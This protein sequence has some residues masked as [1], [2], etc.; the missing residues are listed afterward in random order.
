MKTLQYALL[1]L[2]AALLSSTLGFSQTLTSSEFF[3]PE[4]KYKCEDNLIEVMFIETS[5]VRLRNGQPADLI[6]DA[7]TGIDNLLA[8]LEWHQWSR[9]CDVDESVIDRW[10]EDGERNS[11]QP[12]YNLNNIYRLKILEGHDIWQICRQLE[13]LPGI[14]QARPYPLPVEPP[15]PPNYQNNQG[16]LKPSTLN[17][18]GIDALYA[19]TQTGGAGTGITICDL[20]YSWNYNHADITKAVGSSL[21]AWSDPGFGNDH[22]TA[23]IGQLVSN[24]NGWG[25]TGICYDA[26]LK[27]C[28]TYYGTPS[29]V[30]N[31][32]GAMALAIANLSAGDI[33]LLEQQWDYTGTNGYVPIE[34]WTNSN[35]AQTNNAV[36]SAIVNAVA[37]GIHVVE[38]GGNGNINTGS[39][40]WFGYSGAIIVGA[41]GAFTYN[42]RER[43]SF[44]SYGPRFDLQ[45]WGQNVTTTG[46]GDLYNA[47]GIN[48]YYTS[49]FG[50]TSSA[51]PIVTGAIACTQGYYLANVSATPLT[52]SQ[53]RSHLDTYS[54][55]Q[56]FGILGHI[57]PR[58]DLNQAILALQ[59]PP[60]NQYDWGDAPDPSY[61]TLSVNNGARHYIDWTIYLGNGVDADPDGQPNPYALGDDNDGNDDEDGVLFTSVIMANQPATITVFA[62]AN[63]FLNAWFDFNFNGSWND[64]GEQVFTDVPVV[65]GANNLNYFVPPVPSSQYTFTRFRY[66]TLPGLAP[67]G[68]APDGE[69]EDYEIFINQEISEE[70]DWGDAPDSPYPTLGANN[71]A[72]HLIVPGFYLGNFV[73]PEPDGQPSLNAD[74]D[75][76]DCLYPSMGD[77]ED[78][79]TFNYPIIPGQLST[80][81]VIASGTGF[82]N[83][84]IDQDFNNSWADPGDH[85]FADVPLVPGANALNFVA[86]PGGYTGNTYARFRF[87]SLP[88]LTYTGQAPDGEVEDYMIFIDDDGNEFDFGDAPED[89]SGNYPVTLGFNGAHH[90][91]VPGIYLGSFVDPEPDGQ[92]SPGAD[93]DDTDCLF[94]SFGDDEDGVTMPAIINPGAAIDITVTASVDGF[95]DVWIDFNAD[96]DWADPDDHVFINNSLTA[97]ATVLT[98]IVPANASVG[99]SYARFRFRDY[100]TNISYDGYVQNGEVEDYSIIIE[101]PET[102]FDFGDAPEN[103]TGDYPTTLA[104]N[105]ARHIY[106]PTIFLGS[107]VDPEPDGQPGFNADCDDTDCLY[108]SSGDDED[109]VNLPA[110]LAPGSTQIIDVTASVS[111][112]L[113]IWLDIDGNNSW[114]DAG[115]HILANSAMSPGLNTILFFVPINAV[116][117]LQSYMRLRFRDYSGNISYEGL[118]QNGEVEDYAVMFGEPEPGFDF[119]DAPENATGD[120]PTTLAFN[121]AHH[122][123]VPGIFLGNFVDPEPD[124]QP[125][126]GANCDDYDCNYPSLGDDEDGVIIPSVM[127]KG[128]TYTIAVTASVDGYLD[129]WMDFNLNTSWADAGEH[130]F[131]NTFLTAGANALVFNVPANATSGQS[132][133][134][135]RFRDNNA[136]ISFDGYVQNGEVEDYSIIIEDGDVLFDFGDAPENAAGDYPTTLTFNGA[137]HIF[138]PTI[139]LGSFVDPEPDGQ[140]GINADCDDLDCLFPS[141]G[142]DED[143]VVIPSSVS[144][145]TSITIIVTASVDGYLDA[146]M[147][148]NLNTSWSDAGEHIFI[149]A[150]LISGANLLVF[151]VPA[152]ATTGQSYVRFRFRGNNAPISYDG[153]VANGEVEDYAISIDA[154]QINIDVGVILGG[155]VL[156]TWIPGNP[157]IMGTN[158]NSNMYLPLSQPYNDPVA[159]WDYP[160]I[161]NVISIPNGNVVDWLVVELRE[162]AGGPATATAATTIHKQAAFLLNDGSVV[163]LDGFSLP[164]ANYNVTQN[165][166]VVIW[167]RNH[168]G[169]MSANPMSFDG[170][171][172]YSYDFISSSGAAYGTNAQIQLAPGFY[173]IIP[174]DALP[175][176]QIDQF[177]K[178]NVWNFQAGS[179]GYLEADFNLKGQVDNVDKNDHWAPNTGKG[180]QIP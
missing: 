94:P 143:G 72:S 118:V 127:T 78:G 103:A 76:T 144:K 81:N 89:P 30:W 157:I 35:S 140:P 66:S 79:I 106:D 95:L 109:G 108:P 178:N 119:G 162:T 49:T 123:I 148:F 86:S 34:W 179:S 74:C 134:R 146:W 63:G 54:T 150:P 10:S 28:G 180:I 93:C 125:D 27:T 177:D 138:D 101:D 36:Y 83:V 114:A 62:S 5:K 43:L 55:P 139:F 128:V 77:D 38:A 107:F 110:I 25:T 4:N 47:E 105:G 136:P 17:P 12:V 24:N 92:P 13:E 91:I 16:Y 53:M 41:G 168:L 40:S 152:N 175:D 156:P 130:I 164:M 96:N 31:V 23:V 158:L 121:G 169:I 172:T 33:I 60:P 161:E 154:A 171:M 145:G 155:A 170:V 133:I 98:F 70:A 166:Y 82:L 18:S 160:G 3:Q 113:D 50:G 90:T 129:A 116:P 48:N 142:D 85:V 11:G 19:W 122:T 124:G 173:G 65:P 80:I 15:I 9:F 112:Y 120:Y 84:W 29:P 32:P 22:G 141:L 111:G 71:G 14:Y 97:G 151:N 42:D 165:L 67:T 75:D 137:R 46:Y 20:E 44:S 104:F 2:C 87:S 73:D 176:G 56:I 6:S 126:P 8:T 102:E 117:G 7:T 52:P 57:G 159:I 69:V 61:P 21:N 132:F 88:G 131:T 135:F 147:D 26:S 153:L 68:L 59:P 64:P 1:L 37:N 149:D 99:Q 45:G 174:G 115:E 58:P 163:A 100:N 51:S 39:L 167:H